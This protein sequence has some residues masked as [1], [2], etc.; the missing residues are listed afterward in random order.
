MHTTAVLLSKDGRGE[1]FGDRLIRRVCWTFKSKNLA[2]VSHNVYE[3][4]R[5]PSRRWSHASKDIVSAESRS[6]QATRRCCW[7]GR[8]AAATMEGLTT[9][10]FSLSAYLLLVCR[11]SLLE[12]PTWLI[13]P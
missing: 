3:G 8:L 12:D 2:V 9:D 5:L 7:A 11:T 6:T 13:S 10:L 1:V 4:K